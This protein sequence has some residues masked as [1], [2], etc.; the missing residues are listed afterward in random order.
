MLRRGWSVLAV[1]AQAAAIQTL[2]ARPELAELGA[3]PDTRVSRF[4]DARWPETDL[5]NSSFAL[6]LCPRAGFL[7]MWQRIHDGL[8]PG[9][10]FCGQLYGDRDEWAGDPTNS[11][12]TR[13][14]ADDLL[15]G[16]EVEMFREEETDSK[17]LRGK[18]KHWHIFHIVARKP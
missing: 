6:P 13:A 18:P 8:R 7:E 9:G 3:R 17:T 5:V 4:E 1:D 15:R 16:Y 2:L 12:F 14:E 10:R 11:H